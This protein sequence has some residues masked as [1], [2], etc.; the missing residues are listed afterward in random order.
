MYGLGFYT[1]YRQCEIVSFIL[2]RSI[3]TVIH[4]YNT[5]WHKTKALKRSFPTLNLKSP[6]NVGKTAER[7]FCFCNFF[8]E[9]K[10][11]RRVIKIQL[12]YFWTLKT[13]DREYSKDYLVFLH[14]WRLVPFL[15][16]LKSDIRCFQM[17]SW[18]KVPLNT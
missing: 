1:L 11:K 9:S 8:F 14:I 15:L 16:V 4:F 6:D 18:Y 10:W 3:V 17:F 5:L 2:N 13:S 7:V 12:I